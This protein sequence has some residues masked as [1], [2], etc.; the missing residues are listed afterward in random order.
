MVVQVCISHPAVMHAKKEKK[1]NKYIYIH[2][3]NLLKIN[4]EECYTKGYCMQASLWF[5]DSFMSFLFFGNGDCLDFLLLLLGQ[6]T[7]DLN[8]W[9]QSWR[10]I[11]S[12]CSWASLYLKPHKMAIHKFQQRLYSISIRK[13]K[14]AYITPELANLVVI[15]HLLTCN[16]TPTTKSRQVWRKWVEENAS[17]QI[18]HPINHNKQYTKLK[19]YSNGPCPLCFSRRK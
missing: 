4:L 11:R 7:T 19:F 17:L 12:P 13:R 15:V 1:I 16:G 8:D 14:T 3:I 9:Y 5:S 2:C 18:L 6:S 10:L